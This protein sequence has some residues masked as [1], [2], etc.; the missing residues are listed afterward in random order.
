[1]AT[2]NRA[3]FFEQRDA[4]RRVFIVVGTL[5]V[6]F[7]VGRGAFVRVAAT[8]RRRHTEC[9]HYYVVPPPRKIW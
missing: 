8:E 1:V 9:A 2:S 3:A 7:A 4:A 6:P 5:R